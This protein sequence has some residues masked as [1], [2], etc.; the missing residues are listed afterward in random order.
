MIRWEDSPA[1]KRRDALIG[2]NAPAAVAPNNF[3]ARRREILL[4]I[5][6]QLLVLRDPDKQEDFFYTF[7]FALGVLVND[8]L[9]ARSL[10]ERAKT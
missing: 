9:P 5:L 8:R 1:A 3:A 2:R 10:A 7:Y 6:T 4:C